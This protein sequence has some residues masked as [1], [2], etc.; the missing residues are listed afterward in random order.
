MTTDA[1]DPG[2]GTAVPLAAASAATR[3]FPRQGTVLAQERPG[4][5]PYA[6]DLLAGR[7]R[8]TADEPR[9]VGGGD[10]GP[11]P[12][13]LLSSALAACTAMTIRMYARCKG[14]ELGPVR[15]AVHHGKVY[16]QDCA[17]CET[18]AGKVDRFERVIEVEP[19]LTPEQRAKVLEMAE[20]CPVHRTLHGEVEVLT[21]LSAAKG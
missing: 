2:A 18:K 12:Y 7:H 13:E 3:A 8:S 5:P 9:E 20:K 19:G 1:A 14:W 6:V 10:L 11:D 21:R 15:V 16:A 4:V 17:A